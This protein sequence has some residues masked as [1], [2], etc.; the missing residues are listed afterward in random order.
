MK[1][2]ACSAFLSVLFFSFAVSAQTQCGDLSAQ[3]L[4]LSETPISG[5]DPKAVALAKN[6]SALMKKAVVG[7]KGGQI[8][9]A[10]FTSGVVPFSGSKIQSFSLAMHFLH[11]E[12][13]G[14]K[15]KTSAATDTW[16]YVGV[17]EIPFFN[18]N[19][20]ASK[21]EKAEESFKLPNGNQMFLNRYKLDGDFNGFQQIKKLPDESVVEVLLSKSGKLPFRNVSQA[22]FLNVYKAYFA[23]KKSEDI[24]RIEGILAKE[25]ADIARMRNDSQMEGREASIRALI[26]SNNNVRKTL[27]QMKGELAS[28]NQRIDSFIKTSNSNQPAIIEVIDE[29]CKPAE[30][31][32]KT[33]NPNHANVVV[34]DDSFFN[35]TLPASSPQFIV[36]NWRRRDALATDRNGAIR[37]P[38]KRDF[39]F[40]FEK[41]FDFAA[42]NKLLEN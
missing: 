41:N 11:Y 2:N 10:P 21:G 7:A 18:A 4:T 34:F 6:V 31:F 22:E 28:C 39:I 42:L 33:D 40:Q 25:P 13:V 37:F 24:K 27:A 35:K 8:K 14:G 16:M 38:Q 3:P 17:N 23:S 20:S 5:R 30:M 1:I 12:C 19:F 9:L 26:E 36:V 15:T 29:Y 32:V